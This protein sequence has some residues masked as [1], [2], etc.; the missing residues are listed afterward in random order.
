MPSQVTPTLTA[1]ILTRDEE[2]NIVDTVKALAGAVDGVLLIDADSAD[3]T[4]GAARTA[5]AGAALEFTAVRRPW[6]DDFAAQRNH[7][8]G[9]VREGWLLFIDADER[10]KPGDANK[11]RRTLH[12]VDR[13][14][15]GRDLVLSPRIV[16]AGSAGAYDR[17]RRFLR[18]DTR[19]RFRGRV[20]E[21]PF[22][23]DGSAPDS[24]RLD[25]ELIH[26]G[27]TPDA[28]RARSK[29][30]RDGALIARC[31]REEPGNPTWVFYAAREVLAGAVTDRDTITAAYD[32]LRT[33]LVRY[34]DADLTDYE[35]Q[36]EQEAYSLLAELALRSGE[37]NRI[38]ACLAALRKAGRTAE[39]AYYGTLVE[40]SVLLARLSGLVD[41]LDEAAHSTGEVR[42]QL[43]GKHAELRALIALACGRY[44]EVPGSYRSAL[45]CGAG[46]EVRA[47]VEGLRSVLEKVP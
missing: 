34:A 14:R 3:D 17:T 37:R 29:R 23:P 6:S 39:E 19:L 10:L 21:Q 27:Y 41:R 33:A 36:R 30:N 38:D 22:H 35:R 40:S 26:H 18:A 46:D 44:D 45:D 2:A 20:H 31:R 13:T 47:A 4:I 24:L 15:A 25:V 28:I 11:L 5:A 9:E 43:A 8:F 16:N 32:D 7:A 1:V 12:E 42:V